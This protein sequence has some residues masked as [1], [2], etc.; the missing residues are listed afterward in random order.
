VTRFCST[1]RE[2]AKVAA[3]HSGKVAARTPMVVPMTLRVLGLLRRPA[4]WGPG[5]GGS[6]LTSLPGR[7]WGR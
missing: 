1:I 7:R 2:M 3:M 5:R 6:S 4:L